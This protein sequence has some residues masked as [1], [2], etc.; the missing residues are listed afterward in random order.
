MRTK[1][2]LIETEELELWEDGT[3][4]QLTE[5]EEL[6][7]WEEARKNLTL[8]QSP[9]S[10][11]EAD[12]LLALLPQRGEGESVRHWIER[13]Q[14]PQVFDEHWVFITEI[15]RLAAATSDSPCPLPD[16]QQPL[17]SRDGQ[18]SL[19]IIGQEGKIVLKVETLSFVVDKFASQRIGI[20]DAVDQEAL[21]AII[22]LDKNGE[23]YCEV[24]DQLA[25]RQAL[26][27]PIIKLSHKKT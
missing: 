16:P 14:H 11:E 2:Q 1:H 8:L 20:A 10:I 15:V 21:V 18:F 22:E 5:T 9:A 4:N 23:G 19:W 6:E 25:V 7:L 24:E 13:G 17:E 27:R 12:E 26:L 3:K